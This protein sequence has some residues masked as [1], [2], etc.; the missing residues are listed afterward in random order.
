MIKLTTE[1]QPGKIFYHV[2]GINRTETKAGD[3]SRYI[4]ASN[5]FDVELGTSGLYSRKSPFFR[6]ICE[7]ENYHGKIESYETERSAHDMGV[8]KPGEKRSVH[9]LNRSFWTREEAEQFIKELQED[10]FSDPDDQAYA[11]NLTPSEHFSRQQEFMDSY[12]DFC[13]YYDDGEE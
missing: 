10:K 1:L 3:I 13:D 12:L 5:T 6:V 7:Y 8:F 9:N 2:C 11:N 4:V